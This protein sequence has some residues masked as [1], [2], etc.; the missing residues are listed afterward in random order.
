MTTY[1]DEMIIY[2]Q[3]LSVSFAFLCCKKTVMITF[4]LVFR[5]RHLVDVAT[6]ARRRLDWLNIPL[7]CEYVVETLWFGTQ[8]DLRNN[9]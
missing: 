6:G 7:V 2:A 9:F 5:R 4:T 3:Q 8:R 1:E